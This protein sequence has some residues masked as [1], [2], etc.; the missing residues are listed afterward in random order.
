MDR[1][2]RAGHDKAAYDALVAAHPMNR[3]GKPEEI[4][5]AVIWLCSEQA[6]FITGHPF[7]VDGGYVSR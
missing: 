3:L 2:V 4:A 6:S 5:Q 1:G 7:A